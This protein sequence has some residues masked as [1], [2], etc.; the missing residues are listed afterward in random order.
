[1]HRRSTSSRSTE[2]HWPYVGES[3]RRST[4]TSRTAPE[5]QVTYFAW[6]GGTCAK[7][8]PRSVPACDSEQLAWAIESE[9][10]ANPLPVRS[11]STSARYHS[12]KEPR[13]S[14]WT[15]GVISWAPAMLSC[16]V[17]TS[18]GYESPVRRLRGAH[19]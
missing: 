12:W 10:V 4:T 16:R 9:Y 2:S 19:P 3:V 14:P 8:M 7:W 13:E 5:K 17:C 6:L 11:E 15:A 18:V 1:M